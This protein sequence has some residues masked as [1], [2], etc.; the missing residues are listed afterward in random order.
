M[1]FTLGELRRIND[2]LGTI[3]RKELPIVVAWRLNGFLTTS[4][5]KTEKVEEFRISLIKK[6]GKEEEKDKWEVCEE[7]LDKFIND[8]NELLNETVEIEFSPINI[9]SL[10]GKLDL[11][12]EQIQTISKLFEE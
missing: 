7:N 2:V 6:Y 10:I 5:E 12:L 11:S 4:I 9:N 8:F 1:L 3:I